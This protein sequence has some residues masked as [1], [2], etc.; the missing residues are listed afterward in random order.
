MIIAKLKNA[1]H[2]VATS[3]PKRFW[4]VDLLIV[5]LPSMLGRSMMASVGNA[6]KI[7]AAAVLY[8]NIFR[9]C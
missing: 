2:V 8:R 7:A 1:K 6:L 9:I 3:G 4:K 5:I